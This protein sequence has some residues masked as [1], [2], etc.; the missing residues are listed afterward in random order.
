MR[1]LR[2]AVFALLLAGALTFASSA[3]AGL[4]GIY[5]NSMETK[6]QLAQVLKLSGK[7]CG[8]SGSARAR[9]R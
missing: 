7:R 5:R 1:L 4:I 8:R 6:S 3:G 2:T 9:R